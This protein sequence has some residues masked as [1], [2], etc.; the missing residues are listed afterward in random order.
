MHRRKHADGIYSHGLNRFEG[1]IHAIQ[2][3]HIDPAG[4]PTP[5]GRI[6]SIERWDGNHGLGPFNATLAMERA[7]EMART[8]G[9]GIV[10]LRNTNHWMRGGTY[11]LLAANK[12]CIGLC[13]TNTIALMAAWGFS[14]RPETQSTRI[15]CRQI[16]SAD[17]KRVIGNNPL[18]ISAPGAPD[19]PPWFWTWQCPS[20]PSA[21]CKCWRKQTKSC[22][23]RE[24]SMQG[25]TCPRPLPTSLNAWQPAPMGFWK[26][27]GLATDVGPAGGIPGGWRL[28]RRY[29]RHRLRKERVSGVCRTD[30]QAIGVHQDLEQVRRRLVDLAPRPRHRYVANPTRKPQIRGPRHHGSMARFRVTPRQL[31]AS[32]KSTERRLCPLSRRQQAGYCRARRLHDKRFGY[33]PVLCRV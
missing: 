7:V 26:G 6:G 21:R 19:E 4:A 20:F 9:V 5:I 15:T 31:E 14:G 2:D 13:F 30:P 3:G 23:S 12:G 16:T 22:P 28:H 18:I 32:L 11:G 1:L 27:T 10:P 17:A 24:G 25:A 8:Q 33:A 29:H